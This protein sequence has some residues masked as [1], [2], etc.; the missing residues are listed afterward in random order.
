[1]FTSLSKILFNAWVSQTRKQT[2]KI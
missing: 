1:M 2:R